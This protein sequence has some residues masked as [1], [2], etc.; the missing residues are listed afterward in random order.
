MK[1]LRKWLTIVIVGFFAIGTIF[2]NGSSDSAEANQVTLN[3]LDYI[4]ATAPGYAENEAIW[5]E[6]TD[7]NS[8]ISIVKEEL[9]NEAFHQKMAAYVAAGTIPDVMYMYPSGRSTTIHEM[10]LVKDLAPLLGDDFLSHF[11][12]AAIDPSGQVSPYLAELPQSIT[13]SSIMYTNTKLLDDMG[14]KIPET[15]ADLKAMVPLLKAK[16]IQTILMA[17]KDDWVMQSCLFSTVAGR[18]LDSEWIESV[19]KGEAQFTDKAFIDALTFI[20]TMYQDGVI[21]PNTIQVSYG[22]A[23]ALF[24]AGKAAFYIDGDWRQNAFITDPSSGTALISPEAQE[25]DFN[26]MNFPIIPGEKNPGV[27]SAIL[28]CGYGISTAIPEGSE[29]EAAAIR[30]VKYLYSKDVQ[31]QYLEVGRYITSRNDV[32]SDKLEPFITKMMT[33]HDSIGNTSDV[34]DGVL[35]STVYS[36]INS[37]LQ[38]IGLGLKTPAQVAAAVQEAMDTQISSK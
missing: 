16:G 22:E 7:S 15:Y 18:F 5:Q 35:D 38:E 33:F 14:L 19:K 34:L 11:V 6:F 27:T 2:A 24:A 17:N 20:Q 8:D 1:S 3:V 31:K 29:K 36:V 25:N 4:D 13:Y 28:G 26:F 30:L 37:G 32:T 21:S 9:S 12:S 10:K 23:P